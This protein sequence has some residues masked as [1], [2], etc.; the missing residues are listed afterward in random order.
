M[1][2]RKMKTSGMLLCLALCA[3]CS[4]DN[5]EPGVAQPPVASYPL[6]IEVTETIF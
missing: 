4:S 5:D 3:A 6:T 2:N 1:M